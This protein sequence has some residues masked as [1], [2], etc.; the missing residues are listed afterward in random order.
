MCT[1]KEK[2]CFD[3]ELF[4]ELIESPVNPIFLNMSRPLTGSLN[5]LV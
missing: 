2:Q 1:V 4:S 3:W 5:P